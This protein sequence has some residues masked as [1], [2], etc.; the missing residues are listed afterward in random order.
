MRKISDYN[1]LQLAEDPRFIDWVTNPTIEKDEYWQ[2]IQEHYPLIEKEILTAKKIV[3]SYLPIE[4]GIPP[5]RIQAVWHKINSKK[6]NQFK[7]YWNSV[8]AILVISVLVGGGII[9]KERQKNNTY[10]DFEE[11]VEAYSQ[12][13]S[14]N[15]PPILFEQN[16]VDLDFSNEQGIVVNNDSILN[17]GDN[18]KVSESIMEKIVVPYGKRIILTL[19]DNSRICINSGSQ[20]VFPR[21]FTKSK[22]E[23][24]L[25]GE[26]LF[27]ITH[28]AKMPFVVHTKQ[29]S[30]KVLGTSFNIKAYAD[31]DYEETV[32]VSGKVSLS[33]K[34]IWDNPTVLY[35]GQMGKLASEAEQIRV[36]KVDVE[37]YT[38]WA[39][40]YLLF[41][42]KMANEVLQQI[43]RYYNKK[44]EIIGSANNVTFTGK[45]DLTEDFDVLL[46]R[47]TKTSSLRC[48]YENDKIIIQQ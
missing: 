37:T 47:I 25:V 26:A 14:N 19:S 13:Y 34:N 42:N 1:A 28:K 33:N 5:A 3:E 16:Q 6:K 12:L 24:Y 2:D 15:Q 29:S 20:L 10:L 7:I 43:G 27:D 22:R 48:F 40:G 31:E 44:I 18:E 32:L 9:F 35:P 30:V 8:A 36:R 23:V 41:K 4:N 46:K 21:K 45:L 17:I 39:K 11:N 38:S